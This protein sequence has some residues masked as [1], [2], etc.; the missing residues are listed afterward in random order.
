M[1]ETT[2]TSKDALNA[3][4]RGKRPTKPNNGRGSGYRRSPNISGNQSD[5]QS[6][7][8]DGNP[9]KRTNQGRGRGAGGPARRG[10]SNA[11]AVNVNTNAGTDGESSAMSSLQKVITD[12]KSIQSPA[13]ATPVSYTQ[14]A[15]SNLTPT[16]A[17]FQPSFSP[18]EPPPRHRKAQSMGPSPTG[19]NANQ[20]SPYLDSMNE[21]AEVQNGDTS[22]PPMAQFQ[23][24]QPMGSF[25]APRFSALQNQG[26]AQE[27]ADNVGASGRPQ[28][29]PSFS[30]GAK[31]RTN[32]I[33]VGP[34]IG[35]EDAGFQ[36]PQQTQ[37]T[38]HAESGGA[39]QQAQGQN[40]PHRR[41]GSEINGIMSQ[42]VRTY[43]VDDPLS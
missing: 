7:T 43:D 14:A 2:P 11:N 41:T 32:S 29:A 27:L 16:A 35:E 10:G 42:Q 34:A 4:G 18:T 17:P 8:S 33:S 31:R 1:S 12:L 21:D 36:F 23:P 9:K 28:L 13:T 30:F 26:A 19:Y 15:Q 22:L 25:S 6:Q 37:Q 5:T 40:N 3:G 24:R 20:Y 39:N 38:F